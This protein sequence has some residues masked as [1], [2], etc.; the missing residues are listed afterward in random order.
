MSKPNEHLREEND[1]LPQQNDS[2]HIE[3]SETET[4][5]PVETVSDNVRI[6]KEAFQDIDTD[7]IEAIL[8]S[9]NGNVDSS[10]DV[11]LG[12]SDPQYQPTPPPMPPRPQSDTPPYAYWQHHEGSNIDDQLRRDEEYAKKLALEDQRRAKQRQQPKRE[13]SEDDSIFNFQEELPIIKEKMKEAGNAA[14]RK[15]L[16]F[17][18]QLKASRNDSQFGSGNPSASSSIPAT[19]AQYK[20]LSDDGDDL[21]SGDVSALHLSD[22]D[23]YRQTNAMNKSEKRDDIIHVN[24]PSENLT[25]HTSTSDAQLKADEDYARQLIEEE[26]L[27]RQ[28]ST[29]RNDLHTAQL[30]SR[31][32]G[33]PV[34][35]TPKSPLELGDS[36]Y[37]DIGLNAAPIKHDKPHE[38]SVPYVIG[39]DEDSDLEEEP[40]DLQQLKVETPTQKTTNEHSATAEKDKKGSIN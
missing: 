25:V 32:P 28:R 39:D 21:L 14:K 27:A 4:Q 13:Q 40:R 17:Y 8:Q 36:D 33:S 22:Y 34:V 26:K 20:G 9:Q 31:K 24:P 12:M 2:L 37:E 7:V 29:E 19:N 3:H 38:E 35:I 10:F 5:N 1:T 6:L 16:D 30:S 18:N 15:V 11:L 23:V